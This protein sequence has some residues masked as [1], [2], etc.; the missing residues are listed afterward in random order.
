MFYK[1]L[2]SKVPGGDVTQIDSYLNSL[3]LPTLY[4]DQN[5]RMTADITN[6]E[7]RTAISRLKLS[8]SP[9][10]DGYTAEW[11]KEIK[12]LVDYT[13]WLYSPH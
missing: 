5:R 1:N 2:Y 12:K 3:K 4:E 10:S 9:G 6:D 11:H 8:K 7:L 13:V